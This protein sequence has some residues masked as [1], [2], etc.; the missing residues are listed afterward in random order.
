M[1]GS[2]LAWNSITILVRGGRL[3]M[4]TMFA[5]FRD[6]NVALSWKTTPQRALFEKRAFAVYDAEVR[7]MLSDLQVGQVVVDIGGGRTFHF[8]QAHPRGVRPFALWTV[9]VDSEELALNRSADRVI[10]ADACG[11]IPIASGSADVVLCRAG[12]EHFHDT[13]RFVQNCRRL[14]KPGGRMVV[15]FANTWA[16]SS[17]LNRMIPAWLARR[18]L[19]GL[20]PNAA[21]YQGFKA[22][23]DKCSYREFEQLLR[24]EKLE[25][26]Q[27]Y[28][29]YYSSSYFQF[30]FP[31]H[32]ISIL[33]DL[34]R[35]T[36]GWKLLS[37]M[38]LFVV[39]KE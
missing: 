12:I 33:L 39:R 2:W 37:S 27:G 1:L 18:L 3:F 8:E 38:N 15:T 36:L 5:K 9:D 21:G 11:D 6:L 32:C 35:Q 26:I 7:R 13:T 31:L 25:I 23:Y 24:Q 28:C 30:F 4:Q 16:P 29:S 14:L 20:V 22:H 34:V 17:V 10:Q 19:F